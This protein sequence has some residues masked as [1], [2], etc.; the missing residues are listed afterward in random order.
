MIH[1]T[2]SFLFCLALLAGLVGVSPAAAA[3]TLLSFTVEAQANSVLATWETASEVDNVGFNLYRA[4]E[5]GGLRTLLT[6]IPSQGPGS[7]QGFVYTYEDL[8]VQAGN[9]YYYW[10]EGISPDGSTVLFGP[11]S[12]T[13]GG[14]TAVTLGGVSASPAA[15]AA[16]PWLL[17]AAGAGL[18]LGLSRLRRRA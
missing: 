13:Y 14:P 11:A 17:V 10:L 5:V 4:D 1:K 6:T 16:A 7:V 18:A 2:K 8:A 12:V 15:G 9:T 3:V